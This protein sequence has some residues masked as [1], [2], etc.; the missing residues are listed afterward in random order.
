MGTRERIDPVQSEQLV[1][2]MNNIIAEIE[3]VL[4]S[5]DGFNSALPDQYWNKRGSIKFEHES[6]K[7]SFKFEDTPYGYRSIE[8]QAYGE[9]GATRETLSVTPS[10]T[11]PKLAYLALPEDGEPIWIENDQAAIDGAMNLVERLRTHA[12]P[13]K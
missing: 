4:R 9:G 8:L 13:P 12:D 2:E 10:T 5:N 6:K 1:S 7:Y 3:G 11:R